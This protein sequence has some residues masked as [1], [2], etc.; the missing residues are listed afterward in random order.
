VSVKER[1]KALVGPG[2]QRRVHRL[3]R[4][5]WATKLRIVR[6]LEGGDRS[7]STRAAY[8]LWDP[9]TESFSYEL[10]DEHRV[11]T[12]IAGAIGADV[13]QLAAYAAETHSDPEFHERLA[14]HLRWRFDVKH[15]PPLGH[16]L[17]W[18]VIARA[19]KPAVTVET[20][21]YEGLGS[22]VLLRALERNA[23]EGAGGELLSFDLS[24]DA[25][26]M[27]RDDLRG[28]WRPGVGSTR[29]LLE[30]AL[31]GREVGLMIQDTPHTEENQ[32]F[33][34]GAVLAHAAPTLV[35]I[36]ASG[37]WATTLAALCSERNGSH[38][39]IPARS[40]DHV[41]PGGAL[42]IGVFGATPSG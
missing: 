6:G 31:E 17:G 28:R 32:R 36:D 1:L 27:V 13:D 34:F 26:S 7:L 40:R 41:A 22:L 20:G 9:E 15:R 2:W 19:L 16:R 11:V 33:E 29:E 38:H 24:P 14:R 35:L 3:S 18:Y 8:V 42:S 37:G 25:G 21:I 10:A 12:E 30:P 23:Q 4:L 5:R 39:L